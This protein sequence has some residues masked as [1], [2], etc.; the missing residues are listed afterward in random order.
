MEGMGTAPL[1]KA[2]RRI[3]STPEGLCAG[4]KH[5]TLP[6]PTERYAEDR[7][8]AEITTPS[9]GAANSAGRCKMSEP[10][11]WADSASLAPPVLRQRPALPFALD[12][13]Y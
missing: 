10:I 6:G 3:R 1:W 4:N 12:D 8:L 5:A 7:H 11:R 9:E 2:A 13:R